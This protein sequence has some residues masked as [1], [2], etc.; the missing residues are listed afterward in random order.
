LTTRPA[1]LPEHAGGCAADSHAQRSIRPQD[2]QQTAPTTPAGMPACGR[3]RNT[4]TD[5]Q[6]KPA[7][8]DNMRMPISVRLI[9]AAVFAA[10][11]AAAASEPAAWNYAEGTERWGYLSEDFS[12]C[13]D[14]LSQ[15]P[16]DVIRD[17]ARH[18]ALPALNFSYSH[19]A[20]VDVSNIGHTIQTAPLAAGNSLYIGA[21][22][23]AL[24]QFHVHAP[25]E[26]F[27]DGEQYPL[28][29]HFVHQAADGSRA[30]I[31][32]LFDEG[33]AD[34]QLQK[35]IAA[36]PDEEGGHATVAGLNLRSLI[37]GGRSYRFSGSLTTPPCS[38]GIAWHVMGRVRS[39]S[40]AQLA[41]FGERY[42]GEEFPGGNR[43]PL[44]PLNGRHVT[45]ESSD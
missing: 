18:R 17:S 8:E 20:Q 27:L 15:S 10:A 28:E 45:T 36:I 19:S 16:I 26:N 4:L 43:R 24:A 41:A 29:V 5:L 30:V 9:A 33:P 3:A 31:G 1:Q 12:A 14:G 6:S 44:Q 40:L 39:A 42:S 38:E 7:T 22:Q 25:S 13:H 21:K 34:P 35:I 37:P 11:G 2:N 32:V 23:Y